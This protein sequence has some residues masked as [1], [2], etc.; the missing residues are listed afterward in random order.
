MHFRVDGNK[1]RQWGP[2][3]D[4]HGEVVGIVFA[5]APQY[6]GISFA[7]PFE[8]V[9]KSLPLLYKGGQIRRSWMGAALHENK[10][11]KTL[12]FYY[13]LPRGNASKA[14]IKID[15]QLIAINNR[16]IQ[17]LEEAQQEIAFLQFPTIVEL[18]IKEQTSHSLSPY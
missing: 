15:D 1:P 13:L 11:E 5:G 17:T 4:S 8:W 7:I 6:Q 3:L 2:L 16:P 12:S 9:R 10:Q 14:G 18:Q